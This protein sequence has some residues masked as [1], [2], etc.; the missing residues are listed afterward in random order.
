M[1]GTRLR[2]F[3]VPKQFLPSADKTVR[4]SHCVFIKRSETA[5]PVAPLLSHPAPIPAATQD[6]AGKYLL[7]RLAEEE[8]GV[9]IGNIREIIS[10]PEITPLPHTPSF[11]KGVI[12]IRGKVVSVI[13]LRLRLGIRPEPLTLRT[14]IIVVRSHANP[15]HALKGVIVYDVLDVLSLSAEEIGDASAHSHGLPA[16]WVAGVASAGDKRRIL[17]DM[18]A[19]LRDQALPGSNSS[20]HE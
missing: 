15:N 9:R 2:A 14:S 17:L 13:D 6:R 10:G 7:F 5:M 3:T 8:F 16:A 12:N 1:S 19:L 18:D 11:V 20:T 4:A